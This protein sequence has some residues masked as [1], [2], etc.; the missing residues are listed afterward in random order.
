MVQGLGSLV[1]LLAGCGTFRGIT[2]PPGAGGVGSV[3][4]ETQVRAKVMTAWAQEAAGDVPGARLSVEAALR[5]DPNSAPARL[6]RVALA[7]DPEKVK[8]DLEEVVKRDPRSGDGWWQLSRATQD[9]A[10]A[11]KARELGVPEA[12][13]AGWDHTPEYLA[14]WRAVKLREPADLLARARA[15]AELE[16]HDAAVDDALLALRGE[17]DGAAA[18]LAGSAPAAW[19]TA[20]ALDALIEARPRTEIAR[21]ALV[22]LCKTADDPVRTLQALPF[23]PESPGPEDPRLLVQVDALGRTGEFEEALAIAEDAL[24]ARHGWGEMLRAKARVQMMAGKPRAAAETLLEPIIGTWQPAHTL[25]RARA[26]VAAGKADAALAAV[27]ADQWRDTESPQ[28]AYALTLAGAAAGSRDAMNRG[29]IRLSPSLRAEA[30]A[31]G[32][33]IDLAIDLLSKDDPTQVERGGR[34]LVEAGRSA[35][36]MAWLDPATLK[37]PERARIWSLLGRARDRAPE[38]IVARAFDPLDADAIAWFAAHG[39]ATV[40]DDLSRVLVRTP[41]AARLYA[42]RGDYWF[43]QGQP[44]RAVV[45]WEDALAR[46]P[47]DKAVRERLAAV[48]ETLG[49]PTGAARVRP[50]QVAEKA[51]DDDAPRASKRSHRVHSKARKHRGG[52]RKRR[53]R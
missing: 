27:E 44:L 14:A 51:D 47:T 24:N 4:D 17:P 45:A 20:T 46:D 37:W 53:H 7:T 30:Y 36:A 15:L 1:L 13:S 49:D 28:M 8:D 43:G 23:F 42:A 35:Q 6:A 50:V 33:K 38:M 19:R 34:V 39:D 10:A 21:T 26:L 18:V 2:P 29:A 41:G 32:G 3:V 5:I 48:Y 11:Q 40:L 25:L 16:D 22:T 31:E 12:W 52:S 9:A